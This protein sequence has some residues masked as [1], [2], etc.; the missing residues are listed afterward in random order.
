MKA[1]W[2]FGRDLRKPHDIL[3][4]ISPALFHYFLAP[5]LPPRPLALSYRIGCQDLVFCRDHYQISL[6][7][8]GDGS[9]RGPSP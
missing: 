2:A 5:L 3:G 1:S 7:G 8:A 6:R 4:N 9:S